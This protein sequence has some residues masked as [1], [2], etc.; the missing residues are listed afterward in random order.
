M[1]EHKVYI[2]ELGLEVAA[3]TRDE[4]EVIGRVAADSVRDH[5]RDVLLAWVA[6]VRHEDDT[7]EAES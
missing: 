3:T 4:A 5:V 6:D 2:V 7:P 1:P